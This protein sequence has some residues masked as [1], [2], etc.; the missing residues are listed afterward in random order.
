[1]LRFGSVLSVL[2]LQ[3]SQLVVLGLATGAA[4][5]SI[6]Q[7]PAHAKSAEEVVRVD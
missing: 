3:L 2:V 5:T 4:V 1:M 6:V 7:S